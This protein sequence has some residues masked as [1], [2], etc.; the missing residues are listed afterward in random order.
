MNSYRPQ[1]DRINRRVKNKNALDLAGFLHDPE[2]FALAK[3]FIAAR[4][5]NVPSYAP[6]KGVAETASVLERRSP[7][8][9][10]IFAQTLQKRLPAE[11]FLVEDEDFLDDLPESGRAATADLLDCIIADMATGAGCSVTKTFDH[12]ATARPPGMELLA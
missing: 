12:K 3:T 9:N 10:E 4:S 6:F 7:C 11:R 8:Q 5:L 2:Q 1:G